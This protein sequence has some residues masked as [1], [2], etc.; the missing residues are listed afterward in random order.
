MVFYDKHSNGLFLYHLH[1][2]SWS[3]GH[4]STISGMVKTNCSILLE[5]SLTLVVNRLKQNLSFML[6]RYMINVNLTKK[7]PHLNF[8]NVYFLNALKVNVLKLFSIFTF[9][10]ITGGNGQ[11]SNLH[12][13]SQHLLY[14]QGSSLNCHLIK[15][16]IKINGNYHFLKKFPQLVI[17]ILYLYFQTS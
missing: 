3:P 9:I 17:S 12:S 16:E 8:T 4:G 5:S 10:H 1:W 13:F 14:F 15:N 11:F 2:F 6:A 7:D